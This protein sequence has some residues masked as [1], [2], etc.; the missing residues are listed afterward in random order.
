[1]NKLNSI[2][3][4]LYS[5][6]WSKE[7]TAEFKW[8]SV[9]KFL[10]TKA[11]EANSTGQSWYWSEF[12]TLPILEDTII[13]RIKDKE[14]ILSHIPNQ[15]QMLSSIV[16]FPVKG[17]KIRLSTYT[18]DANVPASWATKKKV[19]TANLTLTAK[20]LAWTVYVTKEMLEDSVVNF[21]SYVESELADAYETSIHEIILNWDIVTAA[22]WNINSNDSA[23]IAWTDYL[24]QDGLRKIAISWWNT[25][26]VWTLDSW[27]FRSARALMGAKWLNPDDL[28]LVVETN[29][30]YKTLNLTQ[31][32]TIEKFWW[33]ATIKNGTLTHIDGIKVISRQ[34]LLKTE[35]DGK[36]SA[37]PANNTKGQMV[38]VHKPSMY[39]WFKRQL[40]IEA[41]YSA[42]NQQYDVT[43]S[44]RVAFNVNE[45]DGVGV[46][47]LIN[48]TL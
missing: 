6:K 33:N 24:S 19:A 15:K 9:N 21:M 17:S 7:D 16:K 48:I 23:P 12:V 43:A 26:D 40:E 45:N 5:K 46:V 1:M 25:I 41:D 13:D 34:E 31:V 36:I 20:W 4:A 22:T 2:L 37:T 3:N 44:T 14:T 11:N 32:E 18:E 38:L 10:E 39:L 47:A 35:D 8:M 30:Y 42:K 29:T 28:L 27:D